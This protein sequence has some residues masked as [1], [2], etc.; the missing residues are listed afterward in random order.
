MQTRVENHELELLPQ[1]HLQQRH[2]N[3]QCTLMW[4]MRGVGVAGPVHLNILSSSHH[5]TQARAIHAIGPLDKRQ[6]HGVG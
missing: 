6:R 3:R 2:A 5:P 1:Q 4:N